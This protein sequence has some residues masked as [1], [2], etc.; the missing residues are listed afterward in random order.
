MA[1]HD[2]NIPPGLQQGIHKVF[3]RKSFLRAVLSTAC[4]FL[5]QLAMAAP[6]GLTD[7]DRQCLYGVLDQYLT[8]LVKRD[9][10]RAPWAS[11]AITTENNVTI[12]I[13]DGLWNT[14]TAL[15]NY[16]LKFADTTSG[17]VGFFGLVTET[18]D[19]SGF[20]LRI[21]VENKR[22]T[23]VESLIFRV[24]D[25][26]GIGGGPNPFANGKFFE[27][28]ILMQD[29]PIE[30]RRPRERMISIAD[31]YFDTLQ[32]NDGQMFTEF[33][34]TCNRYED[35]VQTTNN[36]DLVLTGIAHLGCAEQFKLGYYRY[37]DRLRARRY[38]VV[39]EERGLVLA[40][41]FIDHAG[42]LG[43]FKLTDGRVIESPIRR[44]H[45]FYFLE[46]FKIRNGKIAQIESIFI[47]VPYRM[48]S[49]WF[50]EELQ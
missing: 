19:S 10:S 38:P 44:P 48:Q 35:G 29:L 17:Q 8:A 31:G 50:K 24:A 22:I 25:A 7:C 6:N 5:S 47:T 30:Q 20:A 16:K 39:D 21:K 41:G 12:P 49:P 28:P 46:L 15:G 34:D 14:I 3:T 32:L 2:A 45:S 18:I 11:N 9:P 26:S 33:E 43:S 36:K 27:K 13:G 4:V 40:A 37:D 1:Q 42:K 23:E